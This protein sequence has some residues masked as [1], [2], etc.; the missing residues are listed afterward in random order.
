MF[1][2]KKLNV[3]GRRYFWCSHLCLDIPTT[4]VVKSKQNNTK[5]NIW[6]NSLPCFKQRPL[7]KLSRVFQCIPVLQ[8]SPVY[9]STTEYSSVFQ[10]Y[11]VFQCIPVLQSIPVYYSTTEYS[12]VFQYYIVFQCIP[13][14]KSIPSNMTIQRRPPSIINVSVLGKPCQE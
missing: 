10:Y 7:P 1:C 2:Q 3:C 9:S 8:S 4:S 13:V 6:F 11:R 5:A 14:Q 12:S